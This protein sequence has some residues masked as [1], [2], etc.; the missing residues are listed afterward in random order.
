MPQSVDILTDSEID[1]I[2]TGIYLGNITPYNL[3]TNLYNKIVS[4]LSEA[5]EEG[6]G[7]IATA[8]E[9]ALIE[10]LFH[11]VQAFSAAKAYHEISDL[12]SLIYAD[13]KIVEYPLFKKQ[14]I[15]ELTLYNKTYLQTEYLYAVENARAAKRWTTI[16]NDKKLLPLLEYVTV[17]DDRVRPDHKV[18]DHT[19][20]PVGDKFWNSYYPPIGYRCFEKGTKTLTPSGWVDI[21]KI[22]VGDWVIGGGGNAK[23]VDAIHVNCFHGEMVRLFCKNDFVSSTE[24]HRYL[25]LDGW[26]TAG[27]IKVGDIIVQQFKGVVFDKIICWVNNLYVLVRYFSVSFVR[28]WKSIIARTF[29]CNVKIW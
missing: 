11:N 12:Q 24:N 19:V 15:Q 20:R 25:T 7:D 14:A 18:L 8:E 4:Y 26:K 28:N 23:Y 17:G 1:S 27:N 13:G 3:P 6:F 16:W 10:S 22:R 29:N 5:L 21:D 9:Q 2:I